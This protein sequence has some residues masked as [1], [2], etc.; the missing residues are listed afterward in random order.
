M[1]RFSSFQS[2]T[3]NYCINDAFIA[4]AQSNIVSVA[5]KTSFNAT[6]QWKCK[7]YKAYKHK[8]KTKHKNE[9]HW[10]AN[11]EIYELSVIHFLIIIMYLIKC[12][13]MRLNWVR[14][15]TVIKIF[16]SFFVFIFVVINSLS[17][18]NSR[19]QRF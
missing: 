15:T 8:F 3:S 6:V 7:G 12:T 13:Y 5:W 18:A 9:R 16:F 11:W 14:C 19:R 2:N 17:S 10:W 1:S 4:T